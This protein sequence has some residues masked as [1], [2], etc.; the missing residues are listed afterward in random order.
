MV[1]KGV[2]AGADTVA[3]DADVTSGQALAYD[4]LAAATPA[5]A[6]TS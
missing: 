1:V 6:A 4:W 2:R 5:P 3:P